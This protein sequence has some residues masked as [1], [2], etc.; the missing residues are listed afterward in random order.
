ML[1]QCRKKLQRWSIPPLEFAILRPCHRPRANAALRS[2]PRLLEVLP[3][4]DLLP[5]ALQGLWIRATSG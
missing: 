4:G 2:I 5:T 3:Y 1:E